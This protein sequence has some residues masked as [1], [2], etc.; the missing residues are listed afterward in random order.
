MKAWTGVLQPLAEPEL[1]ARPSDMQAHY[2]RVAELLEDIGVQRVGLP[3]I[4]P[5]E[6]KFWEVRM[7]GRD[8]ISRALYGAVYS[9]RACWCG[10][11]LRR[12]PKPHRAV[13]NAREHMEALA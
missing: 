3:H 5:L 7:Q 9:R 13:A 1:L 11:S 2:V 6:G 4:R 10:M 8:G 12:R